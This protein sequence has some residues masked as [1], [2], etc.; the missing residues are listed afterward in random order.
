MDPSSVRLRQDEADAEVNKITRRLSEM[1]SEKSMFCC[2]KPDSDVDSSLQIKCDE[3]KPACQICIAHKEECPGF[4]RPIRWSSKHEILTKPGQ[5]RRRTPNDEPK[6]RRKLTS[7]TSSQGPRTP[8]SV[9]REDGS[10]HETLHDLA[11]TN[12]PR[13]DDNVVATPETAE[14]PSA[15]ACGFEDL[16]FMNMPPAEHIPS[17]PMSEPLSTNIVPNL[18]PGLNQLI[19]SDFTPPDL[20]TNTP[21]LGECHGGALQNSVDNSDEEGRGLIGSDEVATPTNSGRFL[22]TYYRQSLPGQVSGLSDED[23][24]NHYF[25]NVCSLF[26]CF[27]SDMN[28]F[29]II[30]GDMW[31]QSATIFLAIQSMAVGHLANY[32]PHLAPLGLQKRS[33]AWVYLQRDL[34]LHR[35]GKRSSETVLLSLLLLGLSSAWHQASNIGMEYLFVARNLM[36]QQLQA[37]ASNETKPALLHETFFQN[38]LMYWEMVASFVDPV[39]I[40]PLPGQLKLPEPTRPTTQAP[41]L[42]H[43]WTGLNVEVN[44]ALAEI[45]RIL[46][47]RRTYAAAISDSRPHDNGFSRADMEW[48]THLESFLH[49]IDLPNVEEIV[50]YRDIK[51]PRSDLIVCADAL[52]FAGLL[53]IY[54]MFPRLLREHVAD[55][56]TV[57]GFDFGTSRYDSVYDNES[58]RHLAAIAIHILDTIKAIPISSSACRLLPILLVIAASQLREPDSTT[59]PDGLHNE[60]HE[61]IVQARYLVEARM[62]VLSRKYPQKPLLQLMDIVKEV[63]QQLDTGSS[64]SHWMDVAYEKG[65]QTLMG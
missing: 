44:Y 62:L 10:E 57:S 65:W 58:D 32:Y 21:Q 33:Q 7:Q 26:S 25:N 61:N 50:D 13:G 60:Q 46:R 43:P 19:T 23:F 34:Q 18:W 20:C 42:P 55:N 9:A 3:T 38:A 15:E 45:G 48:A 8:I 51:T 16:G 56:T 4:E 36:Q 14:W 54:A 47:R 1:Q 2:P 11:L 39:P 30:V 52:R 41:I 6:R 35:V 28:H 63:W 59:L 29:R 37:R 53:E 17:Y 27:D 22:E 31:T 64:S 12:T 5:Q 49:S 40:T 24:V